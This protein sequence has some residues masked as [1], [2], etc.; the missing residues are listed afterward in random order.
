MAPPKKKRKRTGKLS[1]AQE[2]ASLVNSAMGKPLMRLG[3]DTELEVV[4]IPTGSMVIDRITGGGFAL[5]RHVE[6]FGDESA[7]KT[8]IAF[9]TMAL[10][11]QRGNACALI[12]PEGTY[13]PDWFVHLGGIPEELL[14]FGP[15]T[16][17]EH[18][19]ADES[20]GVMLT[21]ADHAKEHSLE[22]ITVDSVS[23]MVPREE[24]EKDPREEPRV[25]GQARMMSRAL[26]RITTAN[27]RTLFIWINQERMNVN[28]TFGG[29]PK[30]TSGGRALRFYAT[31]RINLRKAHKLTEAKKRADRGQMKETQLP[32]GNWIQA[33]S[34]KDKSTR[35]LQQGMFVFDNTKGRIDLESEIIQLGLEDQ[36]IEKL[37][38]SYLYV[39]AAGGELK[40]TWKAFK[41]AIRED[42]MLASEMIAAISDMTVELSKVGE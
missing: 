38:N 25:A 22:V 3:S 20:I 9:R 40:K 29:S 7:C 42:E 35:P 8:Y 13:D 4:R 34:E 37:G 12:D 36:I 19:T 33:R 23:A 11:Q 27:K 31:T 14:Y 26:R 5:G 6:L 30:T 39:N 18:M 17:E 10:S 28:M 16:A 2:L 21:L 15:R 1:N 41:Q 32:T 24:T